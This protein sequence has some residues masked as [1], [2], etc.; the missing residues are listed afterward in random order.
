[1]CQLGWATALRYLVKHYMSSVQ[2]F[3]QPKPTCKSRDCP[4][5]RRWASSNH[6]K[7]F[8]QRK[9]KKRQIYL[10]TRAIYIPL[11]LFLWKTLTTIGKGSLLDSEARNSSITMT[12]NKTGRNPASESRK[13]ALAGS[14]QWFSRLATHPIYTRSRRSSVAHRCF[15]RWRCWAFRVPTLCHAQSPPVV[16]TRTP[17]L[18]SITGSSSLARA[19]P[20]QSGCFTLQS[21]DTHSSLQHGFIFSPPWRGC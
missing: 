18:L 15:W 14:K 17:T 11:V 13:R 8:G 5:E 2:V 20:F 10:W 3:F 1:M 7:V 9:R 12:L 6:V 4:P 19:I 16:S 21:E